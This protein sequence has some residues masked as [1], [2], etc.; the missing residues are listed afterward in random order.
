[1]SRNYYEILQ[2]KQS[3]SEAEI[4]AA[5]KR[6]AKLHH[7]DRNLNSADATVRFQTLNNAHETLVDPLKR[8][9]YDRTLRPLGSSTYARPP[10][11]PK[12]SFHQDSESDRRREKRIAELGVSLGQLQAQQSAM[13]HEIWTEEQRLAKIRAELDSFHDK[14]DDVAG[15]ASKAKR[16]FKLTAWFTSGE[17]A[18][19]RD[20]RERRVAERSAARAVLQ[21]QN[22]QITAAIAALRS[23]DEIFM[24]QIMKE[25]RELARL[26]VEQESLAQNKPE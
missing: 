7:P 22:D 1:M 17:S 3:A 23:R 5:F 11:K 2:V 21:K 26:N 4:R 13:N 14:G 19:A 16:E 10:S 18:E 6:L 24:A 20:A 15:S 8:R 12:P 25:M 9:Q